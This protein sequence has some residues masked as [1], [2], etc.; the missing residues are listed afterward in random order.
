MRGLLRPS[1][2]DRGEVDGHHDQDDRSHAHGGHTHAPASFGRAFAVGVVLTSRFVVVGA[3]YG[4][5]W[6]SVALLADAGHNLSALLG[7]VVAR[8]AT[9]LA[10]RAQTSRQTYGTN[11]S[12]NLASLFNALSLFVAV[13]GHDASQPVPPR[14]DALT[15]MVGPRGMPRVAWS[16]GSRG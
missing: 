6:Q 4:I 16:E 9:V 7:L 1:E 2:P 14:P 12:S 11:G 8:V 5:L 13:A 10:K 3:A 15:T